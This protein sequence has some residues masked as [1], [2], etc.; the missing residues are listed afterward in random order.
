MFNGAGATVGPI[1]YGEGGGAVEQWLLSGSSTV[2]IYES[3]GFATNGNLP[4]GGLLFDSQHHHDRY[5]DQHGH[6]H[7]DQYP[8]QH[9]DGH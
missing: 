5:A 1:S 8:D 3:N 6:Q 9:A 4:L 7:A 2:T